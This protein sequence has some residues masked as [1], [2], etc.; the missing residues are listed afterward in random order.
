[1]MEDIYDQE[2]IEIMR[3][4]DSIDDF[5]AAFMQGYLESDGYA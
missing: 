1:M 5:E 2:G 4:D 3:N